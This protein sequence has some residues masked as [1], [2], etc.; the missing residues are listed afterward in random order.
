MYQ[1][2]HCQHSLEDNSSSKKVRPLGIFQIQWSLYSVC[3]EFSKF[4]NVSQSHP[5]RMLF[6]EYT[7]ILPHDGTH[8]NRRP[9]EIKNNRD[10]EQLMQWVHFAWPITYFNNT[11]HLKDVSLFYCIIPLFIQVILSIFYVCAEHR[12]GC[13]DGNKKL[14]HRRIILWLARRSQ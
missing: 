14:M 3:L 7:R 9:F 5:S 1:A 10:S 13:W 12:T 8:T 6:V 11:L 2:K 4:N